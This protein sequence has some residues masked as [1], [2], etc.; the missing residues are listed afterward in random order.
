MNKCEH[1]NDGRYTGIDG[2]EDECPY[3][4]ATPI[5]DIGKITTM[6]H[7]LRESLREVSTYRE[8][9]KGLEKRAIKNEENRILLHS[10]GESSPIMMWA[11]DVNGVYTYANKALAI[12][13]FGVED[14]SEIVDK[15]DVEIGSK[16]ILKYPKWSFG[17]ICRGTDELT[18][19]EDKPMLFYEWGVIKDKFQYVKAYKNTYKDKNGQILGTCGLAIYVTEEVEEVIEIMESTTDENTKNKLKKHLRKYGFGADNT[20]SN[21][22]I[23]YL[24]ERGVRHAC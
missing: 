24:W 15:N 14:V 23:E 3:C 11:K 10:I 16:A 12:H 19:K 2:V 13:L 8:E 5:L 18:L 20:F 7:E 21:D 17:T 9:L 6:T 1:C 4:R 22:N